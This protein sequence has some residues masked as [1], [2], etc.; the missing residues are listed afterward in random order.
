M[1]FNGALKGCVL[2]M[3]CFGDSCHIF[4]SLGAYKVSSATFSSLKI[5]ADVQ[6]SHTDDSNTFISVYVVV[7]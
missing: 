3:P 5:L 2:R 4:W 1:S 7:E 6:K